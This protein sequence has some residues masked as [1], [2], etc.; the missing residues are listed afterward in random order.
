MFKNTFSWEVFKFGDIVKVKLISVDTSL[1][2]IDF[3]LVKWI[4]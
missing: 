4:Y 3:E 1:L 2:R